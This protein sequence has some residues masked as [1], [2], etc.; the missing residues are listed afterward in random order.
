MITVKKTVKQ[1]SLKSLNQRPSGLMVAVTSR[2]GGES[3]QDEEIQR[4]D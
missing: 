1:E 4:M 3:Y 2:I